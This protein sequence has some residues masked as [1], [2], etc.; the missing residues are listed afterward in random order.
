MKN[1][2]LIWYKDGGLEA[3]QLRV[4]TRGIPIPAE[5]LRLVN[6]GYSSWVNLDNI[7]QDNEIIKERVAIAVALLPQNT[8]IR[9]RHSVNR[10]Q[11]ILSK[12]GTKCH[13]QQGQPLQ[14][15]SQNA[16]GYGQTVQSPCL[17]ANYMV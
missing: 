11:S 7:L 5:T 16:N 3:K 17:T 13:G 15:N 9:Q 8:I 1:L 4:T 6:Q 12:P 2:F 10:F 14:A